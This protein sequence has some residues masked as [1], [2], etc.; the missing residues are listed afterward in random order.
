MLMKSIEEV[1]H[2]KA[3]DVK[4]LEETVDENSG[5]L[6]SL[7]QETSTTFIAEFVLS[8]EFKEYFEFT[9]ASNQN[10]PLGSKV[11]HKITFL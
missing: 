1:M 7:L 9:S 11:F 5:E 3:K 6:Q 2:I 4:N 10:I 8:D